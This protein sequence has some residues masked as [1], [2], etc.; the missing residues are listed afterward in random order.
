MRLGVL[1]LIIRQNVLH[2]DSSVIPFIKPIQG[3]I[4]YVL[5]SSIGMTNIAYIDSKKT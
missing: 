3:L 4:E 2:H 5:I 1:Q